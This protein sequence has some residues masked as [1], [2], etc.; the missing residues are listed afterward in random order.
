MSV[1]RRQSQSGV[2]YDVRYRDRAG[3][4][5]TKTFRTKRDAEAFE[6]DQRTAL[7]NGVWID[8][9]LGDRKFVDVAAEWLASNPGKRPSTWARDEIDL[10]KHLVPALGVFAVADITKNDVQRLVNEWAQT[11]CAPRTVKRRYGTLRAVLNYAVDRDLIG[12]TPCR[13][14]KLPEAEHEDRPIV[15]PAELEALA[16]AMGPRYGALAYLAAVLGLRYGECAGLRVGR[17]DLSAG[18]LKVAEQCQDPVPV[19]RNGSG[20]RVTR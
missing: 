11:T 2:R 13:G 7:R 20:S 19:R 6:A 18:H 1:Q 8:P 10:R 14:I 15:T 4:V 16:G 17:I 3:R 9:R 12:R 5:V